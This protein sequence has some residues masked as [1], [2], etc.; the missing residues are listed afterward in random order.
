MS[1]DRTRG[2]YWEFCNWRLVLVMHGTGVALTSASGNNEDGV[3]M[4]VGVM[5]ADH[6]DTDSNSWSQQDMLG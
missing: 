3:R 1:H 6:R 2:R 5:F 4:P